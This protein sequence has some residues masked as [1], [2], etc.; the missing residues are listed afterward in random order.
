M[1]TEKTYIDEIPASVKPFVKAM[2]GASGLSEFDAIT[3]VLFAITTHLELEKYPMLIFQGVAGSGKSAAMKQLFPMCKQAQWVQGNTYA[4]MRNALGGV[5][6]AFLEEGDK[7]DSPELTDLFTKRYA[8]QTGI[9]EVNIPRAKGGGYEPQKLDIF[10]ATVMHRRVSVGDVALRSRAIIIRTEY[11]LDNYSYTKI[12]D[13]STIAQN[14]AS[15]VTKGINDM[16]DVD[17]IQDTWN[18]LYLAAQKLGMHEWANAASRVIAEEAETFKGGQ[19]YEPGEAIL[20]AIDIL[21]RDANSNERKDKS[22]RISEIGKIVK[23]EYAL[24]IKP[25]VIKEEAAARG[26][27]TGTLKGY[28]IIKVKKELLDRLLPEAG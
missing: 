9:V 19:G 15:Q 26:F 23:D 4:T 10:G 22:V 25:N 3:S 21:S 1:P 12:G 17:R 11:R 7:V 20:H 8:R 14:I 2:Q 13:V 28:Q 18:G 24:T 6:T 16:G 27:E 5:R